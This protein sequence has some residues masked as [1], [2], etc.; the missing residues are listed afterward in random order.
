M[1]LWLRCLS[2]WQFVRW[3]W[4]FIIMGANV[5]A[6]MHFLGYWCIQPILYSLY[7]FSA[8]NNAGE[9]ST[10]RATKT[11]QTCI[12]TAQNVRIKVNVFIEFFEYSFLQPYL[13]VSAVHSEVAKWNGSLWAID[14][15]CFWPRLQH[16]HIAHLRGF[17]N[18]TSFP[19]FFLR[20]KKK[21]ATFW[22]PPNSQQSN[23]RK[24]FSLGPQ[25]GS[26]KRLDKAVGR[27]IQ[28]TQ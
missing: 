10:S 1:K 4:H 28:K 3:V 25:N 24:H 12:V 13:S 2:G 14:A 8:G 11:N 19:H 26:Q 7:I 18:R 27:S 6:W 21:F 22:N 20:L 9:E 5:I 23:S 17:G 15:K 16:I